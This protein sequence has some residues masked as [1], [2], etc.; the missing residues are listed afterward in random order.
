[1][2]G[3]LRGGWARTGQLHPWRQPPDFPVGRLLLLLLL[4]LLLQQ[5]LLL[6]L[7][8]SQQL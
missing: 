3:G 2:R 1:V 5:L 4:L 6:P 7:R 8:L